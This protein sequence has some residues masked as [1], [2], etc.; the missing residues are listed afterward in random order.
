MTSTDVESP[1][2]T[3]PPGEAS[4][5]LAAKYESTA[6]RL[7][8]RRSSMTHPGLRA[9]AYRGLHAQQTAFA[10]DIPI[11]CMSAKHE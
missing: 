10:C 3:T 1:S 7:A 2:G 6:A 9:T 5:V 8:A 11:F 4:T